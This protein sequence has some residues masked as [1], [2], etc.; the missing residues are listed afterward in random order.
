MR[1]FE[2]VALIH[3]SVNVLTQLAC[4]PAQAGNGVWAQTMHLEAFT[5]HSKNLAR[6]LLNIEFGATIC[7]RRF[8]VSSHRSQTMTYS[9]STTVGDIV[10]VIYE[11]MLGRYGDRALASLAASTMINDLFIEEYCSEMSL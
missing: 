2:G 7:V 4:F 11:E 9:E 10:S 8:D 3:R 1:L 6:I 5:P